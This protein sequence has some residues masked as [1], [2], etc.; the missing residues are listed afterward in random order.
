MF[1]IYS[2]HNPAHFVELRFEE[3]VN[4]TLYLGNTAIPFVLKTLFGDDLP[5][6]GISDLRG[7][8]EI[9]SRFNHEQ[10]MKDLE[11]EKGVVFMG[12]GKY[13]IGGKLV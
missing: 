9:L 1:T 12:I 5:F 3:G 8:E 2:I 6:E 11:I 10:A 7:I 4:S 13:E